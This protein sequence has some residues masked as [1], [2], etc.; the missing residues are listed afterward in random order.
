MIWDIANG[1]V[2]PEL[3]D[4]ARFMV[5]QDKDIVVWQRVDIENYSD[6]RDIEWIDND[7]MEFNASLWYRLSGADADIFIDNVHIRYNF[8]QEQLEYFIQYPIETIQKKR[9]LFSTRRI[10]AV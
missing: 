4:S 6:A 10:G 3:V 1:F 5:A 8:R 7:S 9:I 2:S